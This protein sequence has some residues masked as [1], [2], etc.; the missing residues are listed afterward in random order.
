VLYLAEALFVGGREEVIALEAKYLDRA[1]FEPLVCV[2]SDKD[3]PVGAELRSAGVEVV[4]LGRPTHRLSLGLLREVRR[5]IQERGVEIVHAHDYKS[6][7]CARLLARGRLPVVYTVHLGYGRPRRKHHLVNRLLGGWTDAVVGVSEDICRAVRQ[8]DRLPAEKVR[9]LPNAID[10]GRLTA[11]AGGREELRRALGLGA[12]AVVFIAVARLE[13]DKG[14]HHLIEALSGLHAN[15]SALIVGRGPEEARLRRR[16]AELN[17]TGRV[18]FA[19]MQREVGRY[20]AAADAFVLPSL[21]EGMSV[22][23]IEAM[24]LGLPVVATSVGETSKIVI[25]GEQ[26]LLVPPND[27]GALRRAMESIAADPERARRMG[28]AG[29]ARVEERFLPR[30]HLAGLEALYDEV[31]NRH[32]DQGRAR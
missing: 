1:R 17:L 13:A 19:G 23:L 22:A 26:G 24:H 29:R 15:C 28:Q 27:A 20:L 18:V 2:L 11:G 3:G 9:L 10:T 32:A 31:L 21:A 14:L 5:L 8:L 16:A 25:D 4:A 6:A 7:L 30:H 12:E